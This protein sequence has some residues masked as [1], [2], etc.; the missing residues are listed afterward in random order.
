MLTVQRMQQYHVNI[1]VETI[2]AA[3]ERYKTSL[4]RPAPPNTVEHKTSEQ[5]EKDLQK[6]LCTPLTEEERRDKGEAIRKGQKEVEA[7]R[8]DPFGFGARMNTG[9]PRKAKRPVRRNP[10]YGESSHRPTPAEPT[11]R[12]A[13]KPTTSRS[14]AGVP[15]PTPEPTTK[16]KHSS[17]E[18]TTSKA[19]RQSTQQ[20]E[21]SSETSLPEL[22]SS[23]QEA[24]SRRIGTGGIGSRTGRR[25]R[26]G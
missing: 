14:A 16:P 8:N 13:E 10:V 6:Q 9:G 18:P 1:D 5:R 20:T 12:Q 19:A 15:R 11:K 24:E 25:T 22:S 2:K 26:V 7:M 21:Q 23:E 17:S 3:R 4:R